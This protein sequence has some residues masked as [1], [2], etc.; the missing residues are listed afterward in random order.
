M[1]QG[2][3]AN[4]C[5]IVTG[6]SSGIGRAICQVFA[7]EGASVAV[8]GR[9]LQRLSETMNTLPTNHGNKHCMIQA[10][11]GS[12]EQVARAFEEATRQM[13]KKITILVNNAGIL[14][15]HFLMAKEFVKSLSEVDKTQ[16]FCCIV[17]VSSLVGIRGFPLYAGYSATKAGIIGLTKCIASEYSKHKIRC[18]VVVPGVIETPMIDIV[19]ED[20]K[21]NAIAKIPMQRFGE[22]KE[23]ANACLFLASNESSYVNGA[24][25]EVTG[26]LLA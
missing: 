24:C 9:N 5:T 23:V 15:R 25:L 2:R 12:A 16:E 7:R 13:D 26:G 1:S 20:D 21:A 11:V 18:N 14:R 3:L 4:Q 8:L 10:D 6:G 19:T 22:P 17:N